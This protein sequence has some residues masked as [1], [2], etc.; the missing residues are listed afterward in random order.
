MMTPRGRFGAVAL[1]LSVIAFGNLAYAAV[2][3]RDLNR[4]LELI[5]AANGGIVIYGSIVT[6][7]VDTIDGC[8]VPWT[9]LTV[10]VEQA[11]GGDA[12]PSEVT[13]Y[14]PGHGDHR[15]SVSPSESE[16][17]AGER[18]VMFLAVNPLIRSHSALA[19]KVDTYAEVFRTQTNR[20]GQVVVLGKGANFAVTNNTLLTKVATNMKAEFAVISKSAKKN[21][22]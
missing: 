20:K 3:P 2:V 17:R 19:F 10:K 4:Q 18:V 15:L 9:V 6:A 8:D 13:V 12:V 22:D 5:D 16:T 1:A 14:S 21:Q 11:L 7:S